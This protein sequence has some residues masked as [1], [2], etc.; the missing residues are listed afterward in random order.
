VGAI[1]EAAKDT[2]DRTPLD[3]AFDVV[4]RGMVLAGEG[5]S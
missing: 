1:V 2:L 5:H 3:L 4:G